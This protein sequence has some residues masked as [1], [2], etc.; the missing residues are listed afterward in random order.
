[1]CWYYELETLQLLLVS[2]TMNVQNGSSWVLTWRVE[3]CAQS[4]LCSQHLPLSTGTVSVMNLM[5]WG[6][7]ST[8]GLR[9]DPSGVDLKMDVCVG[10]RKGVRRQCLQ[11]GGDSGCR[12]AVTVMSI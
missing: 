6:F 7:R 10:R 11:L 12:L 8:L 1:M 5:C 9:R 3:L 2:E 4:L